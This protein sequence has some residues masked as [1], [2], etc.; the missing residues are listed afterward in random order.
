LDAIVGL[1]IRAVENGRGNI[2]RTSEEVCASRRALNQAVHVGRRL[3]L[4]KS[5]ECK[6]II[7]G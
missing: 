3:A 1:H 5:L 2:K 7:R 4:C 6:L